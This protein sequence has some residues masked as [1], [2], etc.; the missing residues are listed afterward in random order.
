MNPR[1]LVTAILF[2]SAAVFS[3]TDVNAKV[4]FKTPATSVP[5]A[6]DSTRSHAILKRLEEIKSMNFAAMSPREKKKLRKEVRVLTKEVR[7]IHGRGVYISVA[8]IV[9]IVLLLILLL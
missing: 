6:N 3:A 9:I 5:V 4:L 8:G 2:L 1:K 7:D